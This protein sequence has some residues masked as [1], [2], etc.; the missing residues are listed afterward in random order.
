[1]V[2]GY[3]YCY[4]NSSCMAVVFD[5]EN[6]YCWLKHSCEADNFV[7]NIFHTYTQIESKK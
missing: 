3:C 1:M 2:A 4:S 7:S 6:N 5:A